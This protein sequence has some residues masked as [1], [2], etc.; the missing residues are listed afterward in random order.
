MITQPSYVQWISQTESNYFF[1][2]LEDTHSSHPC[3]ECWWI[4][5]GQAEQ[6]RMKFYDYQISPD[7]VYAMISV[8]TTEQ[9]TE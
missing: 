3:G 2:C 4:G 8:P 9:L 7:R 1:G 6:A 5:R